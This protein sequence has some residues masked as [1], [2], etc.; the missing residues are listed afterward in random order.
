[1]LSAPAGFGKTTLLTDWLATVE[2]D[3][4]SIAWLSLDRRD[5]DPSLFWTY[6]V[7]AMQ[8]AVDGVGAG[9]LPLLASSRG[10]PTCASPRRSP[11]CTSTERWG[12]D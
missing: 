8:A 12:S 4:P 11:R 3:A 9:A 7:T 1:M 5:N 6:V 2:P 10:R